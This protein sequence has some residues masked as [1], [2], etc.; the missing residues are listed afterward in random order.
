M[1]SRGDLT[2]GQLAAQSGVKLETIRYYERVG[3]MPAPARTSGGHRAY[4]PEHRARLGFIRRA[5]ELGF[6][7]DAIRA[8]IALAEPG[9]ASCAQVKAIATDHLHEIRAKIADLTRLAA[10]L[11]TAVQQCGAGDRPICPVISTLGGAPI[12]QGGDG[13]T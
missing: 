4:Q 3:L 6:G 1:T 11:D 5:R 9:Q 10:V 7:L 2:I 13:Q 12:G 8:L